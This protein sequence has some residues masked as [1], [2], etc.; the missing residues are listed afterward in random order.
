M[1]V[2]PESLVPTA[3]DASPLSGSVR[4]VE[5]LGSRC[6]LRVDVGPVLTMAFVA[7][8]VNIRV[9][10]R[11]GLTPGTPEDLHWFDVATGKAI[12][13]HGALT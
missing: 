1:G 11:I 6:L 8:D 3:P 10:E 5:F 7:A 13:R 9:G 12:R 2:R 4:T